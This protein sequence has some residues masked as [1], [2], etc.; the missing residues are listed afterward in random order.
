[1][2]ATKLTFYSV[3][4]V[5]ANKPLSTDKIEVTP[6]ET[7]PMIDGE[8]SDNLEEFTVSGSDASGGSYES[9]VKTAITL[10]ASWLPFGS[11]RKTAPDVRRGEY[12]AIYR[13]GEVDKYYWCSLFYDTKLRKRETILFL[14]SD[15]TDESQEATP[16]NSYFLEISTHNKLIHFHTSK[17][18]GEPFSYDVQLNTKDGFWIIQDDIGNLM[19]FD[20]KNRRFEIKNTDGS[21]IDVDKK[22][23]TMTAPDTITLIAGKDVIVK[24]GANVNTTAGT[25]INDKANAITTQASQTTNTVPTTNFSGNVNIGRRMSS[26]GMAVVASGGGG[27]TVSGDGQFTGQVQVN[28]LSSSQPITAPNVN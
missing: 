4:I 26:N 24:A 20:S 23:I 6:I 25:N 8:M 5:A 22:N 14:V 10:T 12:V 21:H 1:M 19:T 27:F 28:K 2:E 13:Y 9:K 15:T 11:N 18:D 3:G 16:E 17:T 7:L